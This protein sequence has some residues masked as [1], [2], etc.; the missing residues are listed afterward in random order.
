MTSKE[1]FGG[2]TRQPQEVTR[3]TPRTGSPREQP[4]AERFLPPA[5][6]STESSRTVLP[7]QH[8]DH[9]SR[10]QYTSSH[11]FYAPSEKQFSVIDEE[12]RRLIDISG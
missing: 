10:D 7:E 5:G 1:S 4:R 12:L 11:N 9:F 8:R 2:S 3:A 6:I